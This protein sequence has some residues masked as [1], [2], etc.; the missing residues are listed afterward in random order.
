MFFYSTK[1]KDIQTVILTNTFDSGDDEESDFEDVLRNKVMPGNGFVEESPECSEDETEMPILFERGG[2]NRG[3]EA[4][5]TS[6][7]YISRATQAT[8]G[9]PISCSR[10]QCLPLLADNVLEENR[11]SSESQ[12]DMPQPNLHFTNSNRN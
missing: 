7:Q 1:T 11:Y 5:S 10:R 12:D 3:V 2:G 8:S 6:N 4:P 9:R